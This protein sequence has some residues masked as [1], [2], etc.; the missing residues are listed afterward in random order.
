MVRGW[1]KRMEH[2][3][4]TRWFVDTRYK[5]AGSRDF[6]WRLQPRE[7]AI[8]RDYFQRRAEPLPVD[9]LVEDVEEGDVL[10]EDGLGE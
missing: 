8:L 9:A 3:G 5:Y 1:N 6:E 10:E 7:A 2:V 4:Y